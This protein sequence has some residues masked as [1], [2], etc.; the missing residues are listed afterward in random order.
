MAIAGRI[1]TC[2]GVPG[3]GRRVSQPT[4]SEPLWPP[5]GVA[6]RLILQQ[7]MLIQGLPF[8]RIKGNPETDLELPCIGGCRVVGSQSQLPADEKRRSRG[9]FQTATQ[10]TSAY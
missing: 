1:P 3:C 5:S 6:T 9:N 4:L 10:Q 8:G 2:E 7:R